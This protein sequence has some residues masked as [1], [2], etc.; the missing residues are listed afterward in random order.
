MIFQYGHILRYGKLRTSTYEFCGEM[1]WPVTMI[2]IDGSENGDKWTDLRIT[3]E[4]KLM[5][6]SNRL[7]MVRWGGYQDDFVLV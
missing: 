2:N 3:W 5:Y 7:E 6:L 4:M 1:I